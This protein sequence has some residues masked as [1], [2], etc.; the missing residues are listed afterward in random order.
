M[1]QGQAIPD[2]IQLRCSLQPAINSFWESQHHGGKGHEVSI[3][4][5]DVRRCGYSL[6]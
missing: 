3:P 4:E 1:K 6:L 2:S 5:R